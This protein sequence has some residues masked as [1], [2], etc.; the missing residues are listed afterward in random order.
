MGK[1]SQNKRRACRNGSHR[2]AA[3]PISILLYY[4]ILYFRPLFGAK[5]TK[6]GASRQT[7]RVELNRVLSRGFANLFKDA[8]LSS[9]CIHDG[10]AYRFILR[11]CIRKRRRSRKRILTCGGKTEGQW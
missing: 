4:Q 11:K 8:N 6:I 3:P 5:D 1:R 10:D 7:I 9:P 2:P